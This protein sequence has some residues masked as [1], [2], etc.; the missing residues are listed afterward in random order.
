MRNDAPYSTSEEKCE[1]FMTNEDYTLISLIILVFMRDIFKPFFC[2]F[3]SVL[4]YNT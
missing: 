2:G 1:R 4:S 3:K